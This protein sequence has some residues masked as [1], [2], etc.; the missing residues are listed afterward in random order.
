MSERLRLGILGTGN[1]AH[2][3]CAG[4]SKS[5]RLELAAVGS[6]SIIT[7]QRFARAH[8]IHKSHE[9]Y[10]ALLS[11]RDV[12]AIYLSLPNSLHHEWTIKALNAGKHVLCE[13][14]LAV[15]AREG[16]EMFA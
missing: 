14:P 4:I 1:I 11:D 7:A 2:Q 9:S 12:D 15:T 6:R 13:K 10:E 16:E 8:N 3:F 5:E